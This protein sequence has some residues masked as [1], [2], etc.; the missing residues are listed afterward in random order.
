MSAS[1]D[2]GLSLLLRG[3]TGGLM[4]RSGTFEPYLDEWTELTDQLLEQ[5]DISEID[6]TTLKV[7]DQEASQRIRLLID[8][9]RRRIE[10]V[11]EKTEEQIDKVFQPDELLPGVVK[12]SKVY[13]SETRMYMVGGKC[14]R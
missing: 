2:E 6:L 10:L 9:A 8:E 7:Q 1:G 5:L 3:Q 4:L 11:R 12:L 13:I 14:A